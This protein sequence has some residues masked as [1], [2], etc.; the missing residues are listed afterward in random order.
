MIKIQSE[1]R[2]KQMTD[3]ERLKGLLKCAFS[4]CVL[5]LAILAW[6]IKG[7]IALKLQLQE[8]IVIQPTEYRGNK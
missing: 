3:Y 8:G 5:L 7:N 2:E 1:K 4:F 6:S